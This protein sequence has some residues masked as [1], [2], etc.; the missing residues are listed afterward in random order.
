M[1][2]SQSVSATVVIAPPAGMRKVSG[3]IAVRRIV[4]R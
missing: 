4:P 3:T 2:K 1:M